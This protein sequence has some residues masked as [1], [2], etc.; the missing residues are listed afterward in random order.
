MAP[1]TLQMQLGPN[2]P[3]SW[4]ARSRGH[5]KAVHQHLRAALH[6]FHAAHG[7]FIVDQHEQVGVEDVVDQ[8][9]HLVAD[10]LD[11][12][13]ALAAVVERGALARF[14]GHDLG[15]GIE[16]FDIVAGGQS[17]GA[18]RRAGKSGHAAVADAL[19]R[20]DHGSAGHVAMEA[21]VGQ[22]LELG[23]APRICPAWLTYSL[24]VRSR[25]RITSDSVPG[26]RSSVPLYFWMRS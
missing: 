10:P 9:H 23:Q 25:V 18:A 4:L 21:I 12:V 22:Q 20:L 15:I 14:E 11:A 7:V 26:V 5:A 24:C 17:T 16:R 8:R 13:L 2:L 19:D 6:D 3:T 1:T